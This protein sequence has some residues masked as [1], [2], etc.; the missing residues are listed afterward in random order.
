M[1]QHLESSSRAWSGEQ[2][3]TNCVGAKGPAIK[4]PVCQATHQPRVDP[5]SRPGTT[6]LGG[7]LVSDSLG[8]CQYHK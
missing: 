6:L 1:V 8:T 2:N 3:L 5:F 7:F 4:V